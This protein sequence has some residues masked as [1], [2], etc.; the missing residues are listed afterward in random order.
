MIPTSQRMRLAAIPGL[1]AMGGSKVPYLQLTRRPSPSCVV[2]KMVSWRGGPTGICLRCYG[3]GVVSPA[4]PSYH[5]PQYKPMEA[6]LNRLDDDFGISPVCRCEM[7]DNSCLGT[8][9]VVCIPAGI[10]V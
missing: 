3:P 6:S 1:Y 8:A 7:P 4:V 5:L 9:V 2:L 10:C